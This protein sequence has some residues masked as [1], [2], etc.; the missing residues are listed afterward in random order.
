M[1]HHPAI[2][3]AK[4]LKSVSSCKLHPG[5]AARRYPV[6][7]IRHQGEGCTCLEIWDSVHAKKEVVS[8]DVLVAQRL[9]ERAK[10]REIGGIAAY[11]Q[12]ARDAK[13]KEA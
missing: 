7:A 9:E 2:I 12:A 3:K 6:A 10:Q 4:A 8:A 5:Y 1:T 11:M 13:E